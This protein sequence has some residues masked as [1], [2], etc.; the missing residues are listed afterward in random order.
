[1]NAKITTAVALIAL[2]HTPSAIAQSTDPVTSENTETVESTESMDTQVEVLQE[3]EFGEATDSAVEEALEDIVI[4]TDIDSADQALSDETLIEEQAIE[5]V[6]SEDVVIDEVITEEQATNES[7][8][9]NFMHADE[10]NA[11]DTTDVEDG[12]TD[13]YA[14]DTQDQLSDLD[15]TIDSLS[16]EESLASGFESAFDAYNFERPIPME[17]DVVLPILDD[18]KV[19]AEFIDGYPAIV[20]YYTYAS[21]DDVIAFYSGNYGEPIEQERKRGRL[22]VTYYLDEISTRV[23]ISEQDNYR[24]VDVIQEGFM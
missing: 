18:A 6:Y 14:E 23:V 1:M 15:S 9:D 7:I 13:I 2:M 5:D 24:Q 22:T 3:N 8:D 19:F 20:N 12:P 4:D 21:E 10:L 16:G 17:G 11:V